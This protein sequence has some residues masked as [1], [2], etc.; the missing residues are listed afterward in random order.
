[1][2]SEKQALRQKTDTHSFL[3]AIFL[4]GFEPMRRR[5]WRRV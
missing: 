4:N 1:M 2:L 3:M 5:P